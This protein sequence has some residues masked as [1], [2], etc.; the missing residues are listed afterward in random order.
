MEDA[1][2]PAVPECQRCR[3]PVADSFEFSRLIHDNGE[4]V[5]TSVVAVVHLCG[6]CLLFFA[7]QVGISGRQWAG[8]PNTA[9]TA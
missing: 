5:E 3:N 7:R 2:Q 6:K 8:D 1:I 9:E 4:L